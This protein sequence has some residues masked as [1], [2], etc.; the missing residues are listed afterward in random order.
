MAVLAMNEQY[1]LEEEAAKKIV[2]ASPVNF[3]KNSNV[4]HDHNMSDDEA[5]AHASN[6]L[7]RRKCK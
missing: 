6:I 1:I 4:F 2:S 3:K 7:K 5:V